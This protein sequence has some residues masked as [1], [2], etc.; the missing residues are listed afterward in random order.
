MANNPLSQAEL[1]AY[2]QTSV[3]GIVLLP[4]G[5]VF[6]TPVSGNGPL[7]YR[8]FDAG[9]ITIGTINVNRLGSGSSGTGTKFLADDS[10]WKTVS[11]GGGGVT[12]F[13][14]RTGVVV[15]NSSD[16]TTAL[17][18]TPP[19]TINALNDVTTPTPS[20]GQ[21]LRFNSATSQWENWSPSFNAFKID[22]D[23]NLSGAK[24][25]SNTNFNTSSNFVSG[26]T[27]VFL[28]GQRLTRGA[29]YDYIEAGVSQV[30]L[31]YA[32]VPSDQLIVEY[33]IL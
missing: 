33:Q 17:G 8:L 7:A 27:R 30:S 13:N 32:P 18:F 5:Y 26:T 25:G 15:L 19:T 9:Y 1:Q 31:V 4:S 22:Y 6:A 3:A 2:A 10:T 20:D 16:V 28:N 12:S 14:T 11:G 21:L 29:G 23:Y 24:N